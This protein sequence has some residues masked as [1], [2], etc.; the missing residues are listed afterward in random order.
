MND[1]GG[2]VYRRLIS[3]HQTEADFARLRRPGV[4]YISKGFVLKLRASRDFGQPARN[5]RKVFDE[6]V[7]GS[8]SPDLEINEEVIMRSP[9]G[10]KQVHLQICR[11]SGNVRELAIQKVPAPGYAGNLDELLRLDRDGSRQLINLIK[12]LDHI[13]ID[14]DPERV[15]VDDDLLHQVFSDPEAITALYSKD[16]DQFRRLIEADAEA[17]DII[18]VAHRKKVIEEFRGL[19]NDDEHFDAMAE[20]HGGPEHVWQDFL[21]RNPWI[22]GAT[23]AGQLLTRYDE[24]KLEQAVVGPSIAGA[25]RRADALLRTNGA[26][27]SLVLAEIKHHRAPLLG[28]TDYRREVWGAS[29]ELAGGIAQAQQT[30][31]QARQFIGE[32]LPERDGE[33][34]ETGEIARLVRPRSYLITGNLREFTGTS[35][36]V[37]TAKHRSFE[38]ARRNLYEP[39]IITFDELL[40]RAEWHVSPD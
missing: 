12:G 33:G 24:K 1:S 25:G 36:G 30:V 35:G 17:K 8:R 22:L 11:E 5:V 9:G 10:R 4:T 31:Y 32:T 34:A 29:P 37:H 38:L 2:E 23:L 19:L 3:P 16:P 14:G 28:K 15:T 39:E 7:Q 13:P 26:I 20:R 21:E 27:R 18:A 6:S 40:A